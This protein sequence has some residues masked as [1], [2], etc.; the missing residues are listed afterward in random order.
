MND[1]SRS[2]KKSTS[3]ADLLTGKVIDHTLFRV[4]EGV[5]ETKLPIVGEKQ[6]IRFQRVRVVFEDDKRV[7]V[8]V[9][10]VPHASFSVNEEFFIAAAA[11][12]FIRLLLSGNTSPACAV[13]M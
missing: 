10:G 8:S 4:S 12:F 7:Y 1:F 2:S 13:V 6:Q 5:Y 3:L 9:R 11:N